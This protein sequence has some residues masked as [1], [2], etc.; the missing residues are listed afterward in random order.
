VVRRPVFAHL[1]GFD[2]R[3]QS[4]G[5]FEF[6]NRVAADGRSLEY[7]PDL[8]MYHPTRSTL[9]ALLRKANRVG[10]GKTQMRRCYPD[11]YGSPILGAL[12]PGEFLPPTL[13]FV[14]RSLRNWSDLPASEKLVF[15]LL[16]YLTGLAKAY[17]QL[18]ELV[19]PTETGASE[20]SGSS[21]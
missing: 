18:H 6:G 9:G 11:R 7:C 3:L 5:D 17:G 2:A 14:R 21:T 1:G 19:S 16:S 15:F 20:P 10:R 4:G 8:V 13:G 12:N